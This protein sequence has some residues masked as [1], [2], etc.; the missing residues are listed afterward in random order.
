MSGKIEVAEFIT[1]ILLGL[2]VGNG[3]WVAWDARRRGKPLAEIIAWGLFST[4]FFGIGLGLYL[5]WG[6]N[7]PADEN[8]EEK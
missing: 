4:C 8:K 7:L 3:L 5:A 6:R 2:M 1:W